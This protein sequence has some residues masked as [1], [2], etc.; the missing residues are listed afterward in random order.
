VLASGAV[1]AG[2]HVAY[3]G[4]LQARGAVCGC[5]SGGDD[6]LAGGAVVPGAHVAFEGILQARGEVSARV[7]VHDDDDDDDDDNDSMFARGTGAQNNCSTTNRSE[8]ARL[9]HKHSHTHT[10]NTHTCTHT[11]QTHTHKNTQSHLL[12]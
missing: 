6:V 10:H 9:V 12:I 5:A 3:E 1:V 4:I 2:A 11:H 8:L 7:C